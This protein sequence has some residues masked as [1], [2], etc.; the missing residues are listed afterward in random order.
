MK[1]VGCIKRL[2][3]AKIVSIGAYLKKDDS[4]VLLPVRYLSSTLKEGDFVDV[5]L[6]T[7]SEDRLIA[8][9]LNP[10]A[11]LGEIAALRIVDKNNYGCFL[12]LGIA[13]DIFMPT[14][15]SEPYKVGSY[16]VVF[17][18][19]DKEGRL[20]AR[21]NIKSYLKNIKDSSL[22]VF[23]KVSILPF[24]RTNLGYECVIN[25][26]YLGLVYY[27]EVFIKDFLFNKQ[28][29]YIKRIYKGG[30]CDLS[31]KPPMEKSKSQ[32]ERVFMILKSNGGVMKFGYDSSPQ[33][34]LEVFE[35]SKKSFKKSLSDLITEHKIEVFDNCYIRI[36]Y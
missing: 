3:I 14:K 8:T 28:V 30:K 26:K 9:T 21:H 24:K 23:C 5:F 35:M 25:G 27:N 33:E 7:D 18:D 31:L 22:K 2:E 4:L 20:I 13:K 17:I 6:Y 16:V 32:A 19:K 29:G 12:D 36:L 1:D 15:S 11:L 10:L 34:I